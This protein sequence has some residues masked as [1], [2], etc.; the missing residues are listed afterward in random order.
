MSPVDLVLTPTGVRFLGRRFP[1]SAGRGGITSDKREGDGATPS[2]ILQVTGCL[3]RP[4]RMA[5]PAPWAKPIRLHD[6]WSENPDDPAYNQL[7]RLPHR[8]AHE[9]LRR[10][11]RL[12][13]LILLTDWNWPDAVPGRGSAIF[14]HR[15]RRPG[16]PTAGCI[17][18][19]PDHLR[20]IASRAAPGTRVIVPVQSRSPKIAEPTRT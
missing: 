20:W 16:Y 3:Y 9:H 8:F 4:D 1:C 11:D 17:A 18:F 2:G 5:A 10:G 7:V 19:R 14:L 13:D 12:Y 15:W 6:G